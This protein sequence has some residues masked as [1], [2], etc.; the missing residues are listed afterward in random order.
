MLVVEFE[1]KPTCE[2]PKTSYRKE[3]HEL[4]NFTVGVKS[5]VGNRRGDEKIYFVT[6]F[7]K[8]KGKS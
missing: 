3:L 6:P 4:D 2:N 5:T 7:P 8:R 1:F